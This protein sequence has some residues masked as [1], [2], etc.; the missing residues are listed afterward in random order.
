MPCTMPTLT[1][2]RTEQ[3]NALKE[4]GDLLTH[5]LDMIREA[6]LAG[7]TPDFSAFTGD[8]QREV[9]AANKALG[10]ERSGPSNGTLTDERLLIEVQRLLREYLEIK[11]SW[12]MNR[13]VYMID[14]IRDTQVMHRLEDLKRLAHS[15]I[16]SG[17]IGRL[18]KVIDADPHEPL[19]PQLGFDPDDF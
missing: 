10:N 9:Q 17:D 1:F 6:V 16:D 5:E 18:R 19:E 15:L 11:E 12:R 4:L 2:D 3:N 14:D 8:W 7:N 13:C